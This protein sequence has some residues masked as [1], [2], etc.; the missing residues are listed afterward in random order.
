MPRRSAGLLLYR[1]GPG[2]ALEVLLVHFGG[3]LWA[4]KDEGAWAMPKGEPGPGEDDEAVAE[5][6]FAEELG[7]PAPAGPRTDLG[8]VRQAGGKRTRIWALAGD[9]DVERVT[10]NTFS[11]EW[12]PRSGRTASFPEVDRAA[13]FALA[14]ARRR[15]LPSLLPFLDRLAHAL[16]APGEG[17]R[18]PDEG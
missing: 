3:P 7:S 4:A 13:W 15:I 16:G 11:M 18:G 8:E 6:E 12:P 9:L 1:T 17:F 2:G 10:S 14:E 5:R